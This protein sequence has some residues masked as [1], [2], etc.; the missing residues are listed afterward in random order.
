MCPARKCWKEEHSTQEHGQLDKHSVT[1]SRHVIETVWKSLALR[2]A[3]FQKS[4]WDLSEAK[5][6]E[7]VFMALTSEKWCSISTLK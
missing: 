2:S 1:T 3:I 7:S 4:F 6:K 5:L